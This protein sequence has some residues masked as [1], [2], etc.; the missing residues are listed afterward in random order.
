LA[1]FVGGDVC[2]FGPAARVKRWRETL[3]NGVSHET[4]DCVDNGFYDNTSVYTVPAGH[5]FGIGDNRDN[6]RQWVISRSR[7]S[8]AAPGLSSFPS[9]RAQAPFAPSAP[10]CWFIDAASCRIRRVRSRLRWRE[11]WIRSPQ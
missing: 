9:P 3:P 5:F 6:F 7:T 10:A 1:N 8:S 2:G 4:L 11:K